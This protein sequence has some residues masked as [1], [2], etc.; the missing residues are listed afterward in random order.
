MIQNFTIPGK[1]WELHFPIVIWSVSWYFAR[2]IFSNF[3]LFI[4]KNFYKK[5][6]F[7]NLWNLILVRFF[8]FHDDKIRKCNLI[9]LTRET[10]FQVLSFPNLISFFQKFIYRLGKERETINVARRFCVW[11]FRTT[12]IFV[13]FYFQFCVCEGTRLVVFYNFAYNRRNLCIKVRFHSI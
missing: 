3:V 4:L 10:I 2:Y 12:I 5:N 9:L 8:D 13:Y 7:R 6:L 1:K 11:L